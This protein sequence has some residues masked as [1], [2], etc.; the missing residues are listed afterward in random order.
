MKPAPSNSYVLRTEFTIFAGVFPVANDPKNTS[1]YDDLM[2]LVRAVV[3]EGRAL[4]E[5]EES[6]YVAACKCFANKFIERRAEFCPLLG[7]KP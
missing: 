7:C 5:D 2:K 1:I 6:N 3:F 4:T